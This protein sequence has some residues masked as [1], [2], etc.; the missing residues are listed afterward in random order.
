MIKK[1]KNNIYT[2]FT[3]QTNRLVLRPFILED[4]EAVYNYIKDW[5]VA[6][7]T[8]H[9]PYP[10]EKEMA[11]SWLSAIIKDMNAGKCFI[12]AIINREN[13]SLIGGVGLDFENRK[14]ELGYWLAKHAWGNGYATEAVQAMVACG[15]DVFNMESIKAGVHPQNTASSNVLKKLGFV[16]TEKKLSYAP[17]R[18]K[19]VLYKY[20]SIPCSQYRLPLNNTNRKKHLR[21]SAA[22]LVTDDNQVLL[23]SRPEGKSMAGLWE[24]PGG[25]TTPEEGA[26][27]ALSREILEELD[28]VIEEK[29]IQFLSLSSYE[30]EDFYL[31]MP[32][33]LC[34]KWKGNPTAQEGQKLAWSSPENFSNFPM[35]PADI[36]LA[37][38]L[39]KVLDS[40]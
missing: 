30:Y 36:P 32:L 34:R 5:E 16:F 38:V 37:Q 40:F 10:Y 6:K 7:Y 22:A 29:D 20:Y 21:V 19:D 27:Q 31:L 12:T 23:A 1:R 15:F 8:S 3:I 14:A 24:F 4:A 17:A 11:E 39:R 35:P 2:N 33:Y 18:N 26:K 9:I 25:K 13:G 28:I